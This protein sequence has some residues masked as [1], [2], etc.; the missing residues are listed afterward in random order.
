M[1]QCRMAYYAYVQSVLQYGVL[2]WGGATVGVLEPLAVTQRA[3]I[4]TILSRN[5]RYSSSLLYNDFQVFTIRQL[6]VSN[7]LFYIHRNKNSIF[8]T[9]QHDYP[10]RS[11]TLF[12]YNTPLLRHSSLSN[13]TFYIAHLLFRN[14]P[15]K[16]IEAVGENFNVFR[17][18]VRDWLLSLSSDEVEGLIHST[19][20]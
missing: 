9:M 10:T 15:A 17:S 8:S 20:T 19:Y 14:L 1:D 18:L 4:K 12:N 6:Y 5:R 2:S 7:L 16:L 11:R 3:I 13:N